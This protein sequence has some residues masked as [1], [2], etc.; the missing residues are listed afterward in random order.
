MLLAL[1]AAIA[2]SV[3]AG[4]IGELVREPAWVMLAV[5]CAYV[6]AVVG[7]RAPSAKRL[8]PLACVVAAIAG[9]AAGHGL[10]SEAA[11]LPLAIS[12]HGVARSLLRSAAPSDLASVLDQLDRDPQRLADRSITVSGRWR[13]AGGFG[14]GAVWERVMACCAADAIDIGFDVI[15]VRPVVIQAGDR[16]RVSGVVRAVLHDGE[17][18]YELD[19]ARVVSEGSSGAW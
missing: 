1:A 19:E 18:R 2:G 14:A 4:T 10:P 8:P 16:V 15:P 17:L 9:F 7:R 12:T 6:L 13:P 3:S 11:R 5:A